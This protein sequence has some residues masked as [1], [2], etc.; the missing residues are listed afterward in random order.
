MLIFIFLPQSLLRP[1]TLEEVTE[2]FLKT[3]AAPTKRKLAVKERTD[4]RK[5][6]KAVK[7]SEGRSG[8][9]KNN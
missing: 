9:E 4:N 3:A 8:E 1:L 6:K 5:R 2:H 7:E